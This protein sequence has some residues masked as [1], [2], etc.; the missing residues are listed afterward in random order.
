MLTD[1]YLDGASLGHAYRIASLTGAKVMTGQFNA[2]VARGQ[3]RYPIERLPYA[4]DRSLEALKGTRH[5]ILAGATPPVAPFAYPGRP[6]RLE[7]DG[8]QIHVLARPEQDIAGALAAL[9][10]G[11]GAPA[12]AIP[13][14]R[15]PEGLGTGAVTREA[16]LRSL[17]TLL[18]EDAIVIDESVSTGRDFFGGMAGAAPHDW[19]QITGG[20]IGS[21]LPMATGAAVAAPGRRVVALQADGSAAF[22]VQALWTQA[23]E[24]LPITTVLLSNRKYAILLGEMA[25]VGG[26]PGPVALSM[27][28]LAN[29]DIGWAALARGFGVEAASAETMETF[30][31]LFIEATRSNAPFLIELMI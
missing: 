7:P 11:L 21:G 6:G 5:L 1:G 20:A 12:A 8:A 17:A 18:P 16:L 4:L 23:R 25:N 2:R 14:T 27:F 3:G 24:R 22:T 30:N 10:D 13:N 26:N 19:L 31:D 15:K 9:A 29:P 28:D